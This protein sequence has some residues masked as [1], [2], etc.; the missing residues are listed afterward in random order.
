MS[1]AGD[2]RAAIALI[3][4]SADRSAWLCLGA[5]LVLVT[6]GAALAAS[7]PLA[8]KHLIDTVAGAAHEGSGRDNDLLLNGAIY[9]SIL[10]GTRLTSDVRP[11]FHGRLEQ[12]L[13]SALKQRYFSHLLRLPMAYLTSRR[14]GELLH[15]VDLAAAG[16]QAILSHFTNTLV[17]VV[18]ELGLM[19]AI[20]TQLQRPILIVLF[21]AAAAL[22]LAV[23]V[24]GVVRQKPAVKS[25]LSASLDVHGQLGDGIAHIETLRCFGAGEQ[26]EHALAAACDRSRS[27]WLR[28]NRLTAESALAI[29]LIFAI[30]MGACFYLTAAAVVSGQLTVGGLVLASVYMLQIPRPLE[31]VGNAARDL[32]RAG[33]FVR[34][35]LEILAQP[36]DPA[37]RPHAAFAPRPPAQAVPSLSIENLHFG[38][39]PQRPI[40]RGLDLKIAP[41]Q[42][43]AIVGPS[44][45][46]KSSLARLLLRLYTPQ[47]GRILIGGQPIDS[48]SAAELRSRIGLVPQDIGLIQAS[49]RHNIALGRPDSSSEEVE[50]AAKHAQIKDHIRSLP[51]GYDTQLGERGQTLSGGERQRL[52]IARAMLRRPQI[53][54]LDEPTSM[55]DAKTEGAILASL[56]EL[57]AGCTTIVIAHRLSTVMHADE[58]VVLDAGRVRERGLH[59]EL[60]ARNGL[61]AELW[62]R[63]A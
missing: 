32:S 1:S 6:M 11:V 45:C 29:S 15:S 49:I 41:G 50:R 56:R 54:L 40:L 9:L 18:V 31:M 38:Y 22:Y 63:Q 51:Q 57:T 13:L 52:A 21:A 12:R 5:A 8:L 60:I 55:L 24:F 61:Y 59:A 27:S 47:V 48:L 46:G 35:M 16:V 43:T 37:E 17:A 39:D 28:F 23:F 25:L 58:I 26:T 30:T 20:L 10:V 14:N 34:P 36:I 7:S 2:L 19:T 62:R 44:G 53:Y 3:R 42:T 4:T 33:G